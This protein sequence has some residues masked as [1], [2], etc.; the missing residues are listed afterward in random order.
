MAAIDLDAIEKVPAKAA[1]NSFGELLSK[2][3]NNQPVSLTRHGK[4]AAYLVPPELFERVVALSRTEPEPFER[5]RIEFDEMV[6]R[7]QTPENV[8]IGKRLLDMDADE[9]LGTFRPKGAA[10]RRRA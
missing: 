5:L 8:A 1:K 2:V 3:A 7:M 6:A 4:P 10:R 9:L